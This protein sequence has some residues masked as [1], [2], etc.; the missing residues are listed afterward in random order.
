[1]TSKDLDLLQAKLELNCS[2]GLA[3]RFVSTFR[4]V[5]FLCFKIR[6]FFTVVT[7]HLDFLPDSDCISCVVK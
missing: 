1:M 7:T 2:E 3:V 4:S 6:K 5:S